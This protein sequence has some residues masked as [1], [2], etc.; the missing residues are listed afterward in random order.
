MTLHEFIWHFILCWL[1]YVL[2]NAEKIMKFDDI[3]MRIHDKKMEF[4]PETNCVHC[5]LD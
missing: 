5:S 4:N 3:L 2:E 1:M